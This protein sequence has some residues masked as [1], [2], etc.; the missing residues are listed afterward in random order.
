MTEFNEEVLIIIKN[1]KI[2]KREK[3]AQIL[4]KIIK[5]CQIEKNSYFILGSYALVL[6]APEKRQISDLDINM[7]SKE[8]HKLKKLVDIKIGKFEVYN[9]QDRW[10][11]D[12]TEE[13]KKYVDP[14]ATDF[15]IEVFNKR[16]NTGFPS[17][18]FSLKYLSEHRG[19]AKDSLGHQYFSLKTLLNWKKAMN[20]EKDQKDIEILSKLLKLNK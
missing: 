4:D 2:N 16:I 18:H 7:R 1:N 11:Y 17:S 6:A 9:N 15:S 5:Y 20:R 12:M 19:L 3:L 13:Y 8:W 10:F 14:S